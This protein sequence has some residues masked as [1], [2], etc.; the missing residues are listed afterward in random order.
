MTDPAGALLSVG[1]CS[2]LGRKGR[3]FCAYATRAQLGHDVRVVS[4]HYV[5]PTP[6]GMSFDIFFLRFAQGNPSAGDD[7]ALEEF[8]APLIEERDEAW[9]RIRT[10]DGK[11]DLYGMDSLGASLMINH[12][13]GR[14]IWDV[15]FELAQVGGFAVIPVGCGTCI[16]PSINPT[17][18]PSEVPRPIS[19]VASG[20]E[21]LAV[22][23]SS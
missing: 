22:V 7:R 17:D 14:A 23:E 5:D 20:A 18:L 12:A 2:A 10:I 15:M 16:T 4:E 13:S 11:A 1:D 6:A 21:L 19:V 3:S 9:A 8:V